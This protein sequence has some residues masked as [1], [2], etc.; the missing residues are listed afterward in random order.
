MNMKL[1]VTLIV[2]LCIVACIEAS[3]RY[4]KGVLT[5][6][7]LSR[8]SENAHGHGHHGAAGLTDLTLLGCKLRR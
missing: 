4:E 1:F 2:V 7:L 5:G 8:A 3:R 6:Y